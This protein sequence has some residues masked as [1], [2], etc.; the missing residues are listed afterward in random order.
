MKPL[1]KQ[2]FA[3]YHNLKL[4][5]LLEMNVLFSESFSDQ[6]FIQNSALERA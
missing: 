2:H 5:F 1:I 4:S 6:I 3:H